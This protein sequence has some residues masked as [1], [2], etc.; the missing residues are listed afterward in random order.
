MQRAF[1]NASKQHTHVDNITDFAFTRT[2]AWRRKR[3]IRIS[4]WKFFLAAMFER[5]KSGQRSKHVWI[6]KRQHT[7]CDLIFIAQI[8]I[9]YTLAVSTWNKICYIIMHC[10]WQMVFP[11]RL[12]L[13]CMAQHINNYTHIQ[14]A[15]CDEN[16]QIDRSRLHII[17]DEFPGYVRRQNVNK[18]I[19]NRILRIPLG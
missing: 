7:I 10:D 8:V 6:Y 2:D 13:P 15:F 18:L 5:F 19:E 16:R 17:F 11:N 12:Q 14:R 9:C 3:K 4:K 1:F